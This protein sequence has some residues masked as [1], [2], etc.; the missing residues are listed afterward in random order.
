MRDLD[1]WIELAYK[2][3]PKCLNTEVFTLR[4]K[5]QEEKR[6]LVR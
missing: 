1:K 2:I 3:L 4:I 5:E 6:C